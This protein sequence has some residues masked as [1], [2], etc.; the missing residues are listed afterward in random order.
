M[1][2]EP[3]SATD[4]NKYLNNFSLLV[5]R[6]LEFCLEAKATPA[7]SASGAPSGKHRQIS[8]ASSFRVISSLPPSATSVS[9][10]L[11]RT[12]PPNVIVFILKLQ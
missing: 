5:P 7:E 8:D 1:E 2:L 12:T 9:Q 3:L 4:A 11:A 6:D 10:G